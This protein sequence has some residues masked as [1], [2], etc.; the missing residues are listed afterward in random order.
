MYPS[1][2]PYS[3]AIAGA[4]VFCPGCGLSYVGV[5]SSAVYGIPG[6]TLRNDFIPGTDLGDSLLC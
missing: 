6:I 5:L 2:A 1:I 4:I 3:I